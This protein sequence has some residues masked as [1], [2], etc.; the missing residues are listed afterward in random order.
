MWTAIVFAASVLAVGDYFYRSNKKNKW[1]KSFVAE[2]HAALAS[3]DKGVGANQAVIDQ[4]VA[5]WQI[6]PAQAANILAELR[7][8]A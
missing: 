1:V 7:Q 3:M 6:K 5:K 2:H 8:S 4:I